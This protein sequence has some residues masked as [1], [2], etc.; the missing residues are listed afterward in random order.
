MDACM[1]STCVPSYVAGCSAGLTVACGINTFQPL[2]NRISAGACQQCPRFAESG[3]NSARVEDCKCQEDYYDSEPAAG[4]VSCK[5][6]PI[7]SEC[8]ESGSTLALLP[9]LSGYWRTNNGSSDLRRCPDASSP[10]T[11]ACANMDGVLCKPW[12]AGPYCRVCNVSDGSR[13]F[14]LGQSACAQCGDTAATSLAALVGITLAVLIILCWY[15][16]RQ[17]CK[18]L[19]NVAHQ[20]L[21][22]I[23]APLKQM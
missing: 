14:D 13:Y 4:N 15:G 5:P 23:R 22:K 1:S 9:L 12:T 17:P 10:T 21:A 7:G 8:K 3:K 19:R 11:T 2:L 16:R 20:A 6:C 18:R